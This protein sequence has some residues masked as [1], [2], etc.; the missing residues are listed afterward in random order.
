MFHRTDISKASPE[1][2]F[3]FFD[4]TNG[5][6]LPEESIKFLKHVH[7]SGDLL[8][9]V[10]FNLDHIPENQECKIRLEIFASIE[11]IRAR[12]G[13]YFPVKKEI[14]V[15][16]H[17]TNSINCFCANSRDL[18]FDYKSELIPEDQVMDDLDSV[19]VQG[20]GAHAQAVVLNHEIGQHQ[21]LVD[22]GLERVRVEENEQELDIAE[23][24]REAMGAPSGLSAESERSSRFDFIPE[25]KL[26]SECSKDNHKN[27]VL[28]LHEKG[29]EIKL[30]KCSADPELDQDDRGLF[31]FMSLEMAA[32]AVVAV[33]L[34]ILMMK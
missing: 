32:F 11:G 10:D 13:R 9:F 23:F 27:K 17:N 21:V 4:V 25:S 8:V 7:R 22:E 1:L 3:Q 16:R 31:S 15:Y 12:K 14:L 29:Q 30:E 2:Q 5:S 18:V 20:L 26:K 33:L 28:V 6:Y 24:V 34:G 19:P